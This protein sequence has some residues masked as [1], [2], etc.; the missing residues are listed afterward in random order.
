MTAQRPAGRTGL[1]RR[2]ALGLFGAIS[3]AAG[4]SAAALAGTAQASA[5]HAGAP[6]GPPPSALLPGGA[7][8]QYVSGLAAQDQ[9]SGTVLLAWHSKPTLV[10]S[11]QDADKAKHIPNQAGTIFYL[12]SVTK[13]ITGV[14]VT[15][16]AAQG[17]VGFSATLGSYLDG[18]PS[19]I[20]STVTVHHLLT[21]TSG[22]RASEAGTAN[23]WKTREEAFNGM[24]GLLR[25]QQLASTPGTTYAY[26]NANY[27]LAGAIV[28]AASGQ[29]LWDYVPRHI[30]GPAGMTSTAFYSSNQWLTDPRFA[31]LY[32]PLAAGQHQDVTAKAAIG[33]NGWD[34]AFGAFSTAPDMLRFASALTDGALLPH[35]WAELRASG[36]YPVSTALPDP[37]DPAGSQSFLV[38]YGSD[39]RI[40]GAQRAYGHTGGLHIAVSGSSQPGGGT[41]ALTIYPGLGVTAVVLSNYTLS[42]I[43]GISGFLAQQDRIITQH[44]S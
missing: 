10:R 6:S 2:G 36:K 22:Y 13:F 25:G 39:E 20:A 11:F 18:F 1:S 5:G 34:G 44:A 35:A 9:F 33:P 38:G 17:K 15:Q 7:F 42:S 31:H 30:F 40:T 29:N 14:A 37:D 41:T 12:D 8:D 23:D 19:D 24:L 16:L 28:A 3:L 4:G 26:S 27:F 32:G 43:G 21:H